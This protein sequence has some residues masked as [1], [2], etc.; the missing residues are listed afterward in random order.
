MDCWF[1]GLLATGGWNSLREITGITRDGRPN[2]IARALHLGLLSCPRDFGRKRKSEY[3]ALSVT[4]L[5]K[6][7]RFTS[8]ST[9]KIFLATRPDLLLRFRL[10][11]DELSWR[12]T[13]YDFCLPRLRTCRPRLG[14]R[15]ILRCYLALRGVD[16]LSLPIRISRPPFSY[17]ENTRKRLLDSSVPNTIPQLNT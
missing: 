7:R 1:G 10:P 14:R 11:F 12:E 15:P 9:G 13:W 17:T 8:I 5:G 2:C 4:M 16:R 3:A 6:G